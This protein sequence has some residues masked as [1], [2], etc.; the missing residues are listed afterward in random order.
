M[1]F[2]TFSMSFVA[3]NETTIYLALNNMYCSRI[4]LENY[5]SNDQ[6]CV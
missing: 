1:K 6:Q 2:C 3:T 4:A 5:N